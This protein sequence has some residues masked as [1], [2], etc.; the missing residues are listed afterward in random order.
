M[1]T[2]TLP[3]ETAIA[4]ALAGDAAPAP[5]GVVAT[6]NIDSPLD[7][8][9]HFIFKHKI[10]SIDKCRFAL[11]GADKMPCFYIP[12]GEN[13]AAIEL[14]KLQQEFNIPADS[15]DAALLFKVQKGLNYVREIRPN[16]SIP[17]EI[18][19]GSASWSVEDHHKEAALARL[20]Q[21][22]IH[23]IRGSREEN[24]SIQTM[25]TYQA[26]PKGRGLIKDAHVK[27]A[28][29][30]KFDE[31]K[32]SRDR[33]DEIARETTYIEALRERSMKL[34]DIAQKLAAFYST[35]KKEAAFAAEI[36]RM[37][38]LTR[39]ASKIVTEG[40]GSADATIRE[41]LKA[42]S[43]HQATI[44][45]I[46]LLRDQTHLQLKKW[47]EYFPKWAELKVE[48]DDT[49]EKFFRNFYR[50]LAE[51]YMEQQNWGT[52]KK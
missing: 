43:N 19:D 52:K 23:W 41:V 8:S 47:D 25:K 1:E 45:T 38:D 37:Q 34:N 13:T 50:F 20:Q 21:E 24:Q 44:D 48:R 28:G 33:V 15:V 18:L 12:M 14:A 31:V 9:T 27:I 22:L 6:A 49:T 36:T 39:R 2:Q 4:G 40:F 16:D 11:N 30:L 32:I 7:A 17:R 42:V 35:Y 10:F 46:R 51:N 5:V 29:L 3:P 26:T